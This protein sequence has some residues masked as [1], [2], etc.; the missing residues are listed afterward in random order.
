MN[1]KKHN[2]PSPKSNPKGTNDIL[3]YS[4]IAFEVSI[5]NVVC[6]WGGFKLSQIYS[7]S[8]H[9]IL[10]VCTILASGGTIYYLFKRLNN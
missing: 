6:I 4:G 3:R 1:E 5:F 9:W 2:S 7:P 8:T 10:L